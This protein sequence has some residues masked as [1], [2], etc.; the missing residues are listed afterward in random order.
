MICSLPAN[1]TQNKDH[2]IKSSTPKSST[3]K[4]NRVG[5]PMCFDE[6]VVFG[7]AGFGDTRYQ[8]LAFRLSWL[9]NRCKHSVLDNSTSARFML[10]PAHKSLQKDTCSHSLSHASCKQGA[11]G[12]TKS[13][14]SRKFRRGGPRSSSLKF[15]SCREDAIGII[16]INME[17]I[18]NL[19][20]NWV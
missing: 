6:R 2:S 9:S 15:Q 4:L 14:W 10:N 3:L 12:P 18:E 20:I 16:Q 17:K 11:L 1:I 8:Q 13:G 5:Q 7:E 19:A